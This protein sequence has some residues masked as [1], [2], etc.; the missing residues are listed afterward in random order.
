MTTIALP[1]TDF[2]PMLQARNAFAALQNAFGGL[3]D[4][5]SQR[6]GVPGSPRPM[7]VASYGGEILPRPGNRLAE[8]DWKLLCSRLLAVDG[9]S[10]TDTDLLSLLLSYLGSTVSSRE[11]AGT[12]IARFGSFGSVVAADP[13]QISDI[14]DGESALSDFFA[15]VRAAGARLAREEIVSRPVIDAWDKLIAY[16]RTT[17]A[18]QQV[19]QIRILFLDRCNVLIADEVQHTGTIDHTP[20]YPREVAKRALTLDATAIIMVHNHPSNHPA[21]SKADITMTRNIQETLN[22]LGVIL[23][24]HVIVSRRGHSSFRSMG[25]LSP[26][27]A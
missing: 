1:P 18:Y 11:L 17:M 5:A 2:N 12:L 25:L 20:V 9:E 10:V 7:P 6:A 13:A 15:L 26:V 8:D 3:A 22:R 14:V 27:A 21:P 24:D 19:E 4:G 23:H 16:L